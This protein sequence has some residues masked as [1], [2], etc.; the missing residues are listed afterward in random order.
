MGRGRQ[1]LELLARE[2]LHHDGQSSSA[3][4]GAV[5]RGGSKSQSTHVGSD[6]VDLG[7]TVLAGLRGRHVDDLRRGDRGQARAVSRRVP[8]PPSCLTETPLSICSAPRPA[9]PHPAPSSAEPESP[10]LESTLLGSIRTL[11][12]P[13]PRPTR[14]ASTVHHSLEQRRTGCTDLARATLD[15]DVAVLAEGRA[16][17]REGERGTGRGRLERLLVL[18][19]GF[20]MSFTRAARGRRRGESE[21]GASRGN[22][23]K[24]ETVINGQLVSSSTLH[25]HGDR[26]GSTQSESEN[27]PAPARVTARSGRGE[28]E[29]RARGKRSQRSTSS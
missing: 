7:V 16:L 21:R 3:K 6:K 20:H 8:L 13:A 15:D 25:R 26:A 11:H 12:S 22:R 24:R 19:V 4:L 9:R 1:V 23:G 2:D 17:H 28:S 5:A 18:L 29:T 27:V 10:A 14:H